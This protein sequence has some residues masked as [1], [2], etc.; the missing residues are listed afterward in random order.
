MTGALEN[1]I[2]SMTTNKTP[3]SAS[4]HAAI[5]ARPLPLA[6]LVHAPVKGAARP[7]HIMCIGAHP[8]DPETGCGGSL[9]LLRRAGHTITVV[10]LTCGEAGV[11]GMTRGATAR[12]RT[13]EAKAACRILQARPVFF[14][15]VDAGAVFDDAAVRKM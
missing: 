5:P 12:L 1:G 7:L 10:Y 6:A 3:K 8:D 15:Q 9:L 4:H 11:K 2:K 14:G 13:K